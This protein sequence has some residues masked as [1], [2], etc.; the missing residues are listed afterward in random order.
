LLDYAVLE[1]P[2]L[3]ELREL[4]GNDVTIPHFLFFVLL[5]G[6]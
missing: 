2:L 1:T 5:A 3:L 6:M 4:R